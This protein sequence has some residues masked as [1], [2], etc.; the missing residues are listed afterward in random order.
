MKISDS[1]SW[2][3]QRSKLI[4]KVVHLDDYDFTE[5]ALEVFRYQAIFNPLYRSFLS[6]LKVPR[7]RPQSLKEIPFLPIQF[8]KHH[9]IHSGPLQHAETVF[10][11]SGTTGETTSKHHLYDHFLYQNV[12]EQIFQR[13]FGS[14]KNYH[15]LALLPSY[16]ERNNSSL[17]YMVKHFID[18]T[19]SPFSGFYLH[20]HNALTAKLKAIQNLK[21]GRRVLILGVTFALL[22]WAESE[23]DFSFMRNFDNLMIMETGGMKGKRTE[24]LREEVH[25]I[26]TA[27]FGVGSIGSEYG[28]TELFSQAYSTGDG[29]FLATDTM[30]ILLRD[31]NDPLSVV[32]NHGQLWRGGIN[33]VDLANVDSCSFIET[34]DLGRFAGDKDR[35]YVIGRFD[36]SD[37]RGCNLMVL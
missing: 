34:Q 24:M 9:T 3:D 26:L 30:R 7:E 13:Q 15:I 16:L 29:E 4:Q 1:S 28:M 33:V 18:H 36:N 22:D 37:V 11:S 20:D 2:S 8:Y 31:T 27:R 32:E 12:S 14:L 6:H 35:F 23:T 17:V 5:V 19:D 25:A 10:E 21:D